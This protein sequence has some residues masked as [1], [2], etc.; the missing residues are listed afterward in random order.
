[1]QLVPWAD[2]G[3]VWD[4]DSDAWLHAAGFGLQTFLGAFEK[5]SNLRVDFSFPTASDAPDDFRVDLSFTAGL[6]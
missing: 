2:A 5:A 3:R 4:G 6:F 1:M